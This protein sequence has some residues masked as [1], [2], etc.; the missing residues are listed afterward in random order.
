M[1]LVQDGDELLIDDVEKMMGELPDEERAHARGGCAENDLGEC[2]AALS[3]EVDSPLE[4][5]VGSPHQARRARGEVDKNRM[6]ALAGIVS[7]RQVE[8]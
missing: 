4:R 7:D 1:L 6:S 8:A 3:R 2:H 5:A